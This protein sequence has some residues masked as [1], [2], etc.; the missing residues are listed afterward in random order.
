M[1]LMASDIYNSD[2]IELLFAYMKEVVV[3]QVSAILQV[4][5]PQQS[6]TTICYGNEDGKWIHK[7]FFNDTYHIS[8]NIGF[9]DEHYYFCEFNVYG[10]YSLNKLSNDKEYNVKETDLN[11]WA[12]FVSNTLGLSLKVSS[13]L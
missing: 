1:C 8:M 7:S 13:Q 4:N 10:D 5:Y 6:E 3:K 12:M 11:K 2:M 9:D